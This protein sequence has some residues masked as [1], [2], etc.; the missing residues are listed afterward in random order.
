M[1][2]FTNLK[3]FLVLEKELVSS[4]NNLEKDTAEVF[5]VVFE[6]LD[7]LNEQLPS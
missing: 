3:S 4:V 2:I 7:N 6:K 1:R 5:Q